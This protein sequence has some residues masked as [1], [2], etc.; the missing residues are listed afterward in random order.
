MATAL[1]PNVFPEKGKIEPP[2]AEFDPRWA[3]VRS[4]LTLARFGTV[5]LGPWMVWLIP[6][7]LQHSNGSTSPVVVPSLVT[8]V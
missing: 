6:E 2:P 1:I 4:G 8:F 7:N 5:I 3:T